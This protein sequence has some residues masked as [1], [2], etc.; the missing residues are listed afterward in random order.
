MILLGDTNCDFTGKQND[1]LIDNNAKH[2]A[3]I[4]DLFSFKQLVEQPTRITLETATIID[5]IAT[6]CAR[7]I[8]GVGAHEVSLS[9]HFMVYCIRKF[10]GAVEKDHKQIKT[11]SMRN[12]KEDEFLSDVSGI[13][14]QHMFQQTDDINTLVNDWSALFSLII[15][16]H[17]PLRE[18]RVSEKY[19]P[20]IDKDLKG[21]MMTRDRL[22]KAACKSKSPILMDSYRE[23]RNK[24]NSLNIQL[25]KQYFSTKISECK[26]NMKESWKTINEL[27][28]KRSKSCNIDCI[29]D[30]GNAIVNRKEISNTMNN[31]FCTIGEKLASK[32][33][34]T[35]NP[36]L[37]GDYGDTNNNVGFRFRTIEVQEIRDALAKAKTS[38]SFGNDNIS[39]YF[40]KLALPFIENSLA[41]LFN[42]SLVT[43]QFPDTWKLARVT[44]IFKEGDKLK[45]RIIGLFRFYQSFQGSLKDLWPTNCTN[46]WLLFL[47]TVWL[48][49]PSFYSNMFA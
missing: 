34:A 6:T 43:S 21:L 47:G 7:D 36:L 9:D 37:S 45:S 38:K 4:Y 8:V 12:F 48:F 13:C 30:S 2:M 49:T 40:L 39:C 17:A 23:A 19:C 25:K 3:N 35:P 33:D 22:K 20:W 10:N 5:H 28:N 42:T 31:F 15:E 44:P 14:W 26:G 32:I 46:T 1:Q 24:V 16:K 29:K 27:L 41:F 11:R 18:M